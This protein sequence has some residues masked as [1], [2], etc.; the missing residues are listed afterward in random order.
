MNEVI[1]LIFFVQ[2]SWNNYKEFGQPY[3]FEFSI[4]EIIILYMCNILIDH[5]LL[6]TNLAVNN[7][8]KINLSAVL[9]CECDENENS[10]K[11]WLF[12]IYFF[13]IV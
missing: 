7:R 12:G 1:Y 2:M 11:L 3:L 4:L 13:K 9:N 8:E 10:K 6:H 5:V